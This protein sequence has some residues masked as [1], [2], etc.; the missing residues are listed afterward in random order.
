MLAIARQISGDKQGALADY[1]KAAALF[2]Q[3]GDEYG[4]QSAVNEIKE[5]QG[6]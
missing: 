6:I 3:Q 4:Y 2:K 5:L 1:Q